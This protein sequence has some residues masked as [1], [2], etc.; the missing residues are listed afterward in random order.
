M[1]IEILMKIYENFVDICQFII[2]NNE[3]STEQYEKLESLKNKF[4]ELRRSIIKMQICNNN[5]IFE[6]FTNS[7][8]EKAA[9]LQN[10]INEFELHCQK[11]K[12]TA[13]TVSILTDLL[14]IGTKLA[15]YAP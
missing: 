1:Y 14:Q 12:T 8:Q 15:S 4:I 3:L 7:I 6:T 2:D 11:I 5:N 10:D 13:L 9:A